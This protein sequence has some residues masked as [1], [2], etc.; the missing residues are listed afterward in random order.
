MS[1]LRAHAREALWPAAFAFGVG[2]E[3]AGGPP[4][5]A[6]DAASGFSLL[7]FG[8]LA[9]RRQPRYAVGWIL[10]AAGSAWFLG[11]VAGWAVFLHRAPLA[12]LIL[13][14]PAT[15]LWPRPRI[16]RLGVAIA[17]AYALAV[18]LADSDIATIIFAPGVLGLAVWRYQ[19][20]RGQ[21]RRARASALAAATAFAAV[22]VTASVMR[23]ARAETGTGWL[24]VYEIVTMLAAAGLTADLLW[25][26]WSQGLVT[27]V[28][29]DLGDP[30]AAGT[31]SD[32]L[33]RLLGDPTLTVGYWVP[34]QHRYVD[35]AG[36]PMT[37]PHN[38]GRRAV[39]LIDDGGPLA[40]LIHDPAI[41][42]DPALL[43]DIT[44]AARLAVANVRLQAEV[45]TR[46]QQVETSRRRLVE[47]ADEQRRALER[48]LR[49]GAERRL[50]DV[51]EL[52]SAGGAPLTAVNTSLQEARS[53]LRELA[54]GIHPT[55]LTDA[56][57]SAA[58]KELAARSPIPVELT[59]PARRWPVA[60]EVAAYFVCS[61]A[62]ANI[63]KYS[64]ATSAQ[65]RIT[66][67]DQELRVR[68]EDDGIGGAD[69]S[70]GSG[71]RGLADRVEALGGRLTIDS[72]TGQG[73]SLTADLPLS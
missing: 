44:A 33:A 49:Q 46:M 15:R 53:Q 56:G 37:L 47:A 32:R 70:H 65:V 14:Y 39:R 38:D 63:A 34:D 4:L 8:L 30:A 28:V 54:Q 7:A 13:T 36:R 18:S 60:I 22:L 19:Q 17:Y 73:T 11:T 41:L 40:A 64:Q 24:A 55:T 67:D 61:E 25:G 20:G 1:E 29:V 50:R 27:A 2:A 5:P 26:K 62:L 3:L 16:E 69:P 68:I 10:G 51:A 71:L 66:D 23:L 12:Q 58:L 59:A 9:T 35:D 52:L 48:E 72:P 42:E 21:E 45:R 43:G 31:L 57:L 6:L